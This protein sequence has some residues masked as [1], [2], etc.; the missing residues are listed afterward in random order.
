MNESAS[1]K[2]TTRRNVLRGLATSALSV[3]QAAAAPTTPTIVSRTTLEV[4]SGE[5]APEKAPQ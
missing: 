2:G 3:R 1:A 5:G 4:W